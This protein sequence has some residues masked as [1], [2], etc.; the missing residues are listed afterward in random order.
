M[1]ATRDELVERARERSGLSDLGADGWQDGLDQLLAAAPIDLGGY[2]DALATLEQILVGRLLNRL[3]VEQWY[4]EHGA[5]AA[6]PVEGPV[7]V[8]GLPRTA[9]TALQYLLGV[10]PR[11]RYQRTW[12]VRDPVPPPDAASELEDPRRLAMPVREGD[13]RHISTV[14]GPVEDVFVYGL[15]FHNQEQGLP[16]PTY[17]RW[18]RTADLTSTLAYHERV[19]RMLHSRRPPYLWLLKA[20]MFLFH[21]AQLAAQYPNARFLV[22]HRDPAVAMPSACSVI[23]DA[24]GMSMPSRPVDPLDLGRHTVEH[25]V[26]GMRRFMADRRELGDERFFDVAQHDFETNALGVVE[27]IYDFL[28]LE[29]TGEVRTA[30]QAFS[31]EHRRGARGAHEYSAEQFGLTADGLREA[32][33][34]YIDQYG[35]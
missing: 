3:H 33:A 24:V 29:L 20:P 9:T 34:D 25:F 28:G 10:D 17:T 7:V 1:I 30:M 26:E 23:Q 2:P 8:L 12:E 22:T 6:H 35:L 15:N 31:R 19:L 32:F 11:F 18:W 5:E 16:L 14:D 13:V 4:T 21:T 27:P